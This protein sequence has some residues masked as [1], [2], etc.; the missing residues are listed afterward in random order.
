M[1]GLLGTVVPAVPIQTGTSPAL[2]QW[3]QHEGCFSQACQRKPDGLQ[4]CSRC[5]KGM[6]ERS[7]RHRS[8]KKNYGGR[9][10]S[11]NLIN[12]PAPVNTN[13]KR[14]LTVETTWL[15]TK[16]E[17]GK[18]R[19]SLEI[20]QRLLST[21]LSYCWMIIGT[22]N[23]QKKTEVHK[24]GLILCCYTSI[25]LQILTHGV[26]WKEL[27]DTPSTTY[28]WITLTVGGG[29]KSFSLF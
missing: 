25:H 19:I 22:A 9:D 27:T 11:A 10:V 13:E 14:F 20:L 26:I 3:L 12:V 8:S 23:R 28:T 18:L 1:Q 15:R 21:L 5:T 24:V 6:Q 29:R 17:P 2:A 7:W 4:R 16:E